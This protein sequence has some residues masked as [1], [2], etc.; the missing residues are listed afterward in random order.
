[1]GSIPTVYTLFRGSSVG[2]SGTLLMSWSQV[3]VLPSELL[4]ERVMSLDNKK[5]MLKKKCKKC[6]K[7]KYYEWHYLCDRGD[8]PLRCGN[9]NHETQRW[10]E[11]K[12]KKKKLKIALEKE[13]IDAILKEDYYAAHIMLKD[14]VKYK[15]RREGS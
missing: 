14:L 6:K 11:K 7:G 5:D 10:V 3:R 4:K 15:E 2:S 13:T 12:K 8:Y 9:C 1:M